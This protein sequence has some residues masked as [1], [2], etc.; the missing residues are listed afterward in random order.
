MLSLLPLNRTLPRGKT[1]F[2]IIEYHPDEKYLSYFLSPPFFLRKMWTS[3]YSR[4]D[5][6][7]MT[8][9]TTCLCVFG[10]V[11]SFPP[12]LIRSPSWILSSI[13]FDWLTDGWIDRSTSCICTD[14]ITSTF[15]RRSF[16]FFFL[17]LHP[18]FVFSFSR[19]FVRLQLPCSRRSS[20]PKKS[21][22]R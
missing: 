14:I 4:K 10:S 2:Y 17:P 12:S 6:L 5:T 18:S 19:I 3:L 8:F 16:F 9:N 1:W 7:P 13:A 11:S 20:E 15:Y 22:R 21:A